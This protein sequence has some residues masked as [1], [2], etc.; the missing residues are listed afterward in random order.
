[1]TGM[2]LRPSR[3]LTRAAVAVVAMLLAAVALAGSARAA[4]LTVSNANDAGTGSLRQAIADAAPGDTI[5]FSVTGTIVLTGGELT[6]NK[7]LTIAGPGAEALTVSG[8]NRSRVFN[9][10]SG[11]TAEISGL[12]V[13]GGRVVGAAG[14]SGFNGPQGSPGQAG[15]N[16]SDAGG[17]GVLNNGALTLRDVAV[18]GNTARGGAGGA[19]G[20]GGDG[21]DNTCGPG[22]NGGAGGFG[23]SGG[24]A[25]GGGILNNGALTLQGS[26][27]SGNT[28]EGGSGGAGGGGGNGGEDSTFCTSGDGGGGG[29]GGFGGVGKGG[30][31]FVASGT[32]TVTNSTIDAN[33]AS[34]GPGGN[35]GRGGNGGTS[36][37][38]GRGGF[39]G[40]G[41]NG[42]GAEG[43][44]THDPNGNAALVNAT[45]SDNSATRGLGGSGGIGGS[46]SPTG[47]GGL[48]GIGGTGKGG[49]IFVATGTDLGNTIVALNTASTSGPNISGTFASGGHN[50]VGD[51]GGATG[52]VG[53]DIQNGDPKLGPLQDNGG[54]TKTRALLAGSGAIDAAD[55]AVAPQKDQRG[56]DRTQGAAADIGAYEH[57]PPSLSVGDTTVTE[58]D[59]GTTNATFTVTRTAGDGEPGFSIVEYATSDGTATTGVDYT[60]ASGQLAFALGEASRTITVEVRGDILDERDETFFIRL[61]NASGAQIGDATGTAT[62][63]EDDDR[64]PK[65]TRVVPTE[66]DTGIAPTANILAAFSE[67]MRSK[68]VV[69][70]VKLYQK[71]STKAFPAS[72]TYDAIAR[73]ATLNP[74]GRLAPGS[75]YKAVVGTG[76]SDTAG[77]QLD[78]DRSVRGNQPKVWFF[79]VTD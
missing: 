15:A 34:G 37:A 32:L 8:N 10:A 46:G 79:T 38:D 51:P 77:N 25:T 54:Q 73:R 26:T 44:G 21:P 65:V 7:N 75:R 53:S 31:V 72:V 76:A 17:G 36:G 9:V 60:F 69:A 3:D 16:G 52:F 64:A 5:D 14:P 47:S 4:T 27:V 66:N 18:S 57:R 12:T 59:A 23:G 50:L 6:I 35:G 41:G 33:A 1:M 74:D 62:I 49:G 71:G 28:A 19:G 24:G 22:D 78:Q 39:G 55:T 58:G 30:G 48:A 67:P 29:R 45:V 68:T 43:G 56:V 63:D 40:N 11:T 61:G 13:T 2:T 42:G 20:R 70:A